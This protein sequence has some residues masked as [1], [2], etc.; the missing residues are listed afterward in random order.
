MF[1]LIQA[2]KI[3]NCDKLR[4]KYFVKAHELKEMISIE[5]RLLSKLHHH[6]VIK[7]Y[8]ALYS[9]EYEK[10]C[11]VL[12]FCSRGSLHSIISNE[13]SLDGWA[14]KVKMIVRQC[15]DGLYYCM[16]IFMQC[17]ATTLLI[18]I[19]NLKTF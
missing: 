7:F 9:E 2:L 16:I 15:I 5:S 14:D 13:S 8:E 18:E 6:N 12:E 11:I 19:S 1:A 3:I 4:K 10:L 17:T